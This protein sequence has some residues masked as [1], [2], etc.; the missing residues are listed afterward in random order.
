MEMVS[1]Q[2][3]QPNE[4]PPTQKSQ[5]QSEHE[6]R[7]YVPHANSGNPYYFTLSIKITI[8]R[9]RQPSGHSTW[10]SAQTIDDTGCC[11]PRPEFASAPRPPSQRNKSPGWRGSENQLL[12]RS[13]RTTSCR[14]PLCLRK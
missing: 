6:A 9:G 12:K 1:R 14:S 2:R 3:R 7:P 13:P 4:K 8:E 10:L 11:C 5:P